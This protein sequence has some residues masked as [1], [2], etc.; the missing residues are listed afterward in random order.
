MRK[1]VHLKNVKVIAR[2]VVEHLNCK[3]NVESGVAVVIVDKE[4][5]DDEPPIAVNG[6]RVSVDELPQTLE[7]TTLEVLSECTRILYAT[8]KHLCVVFTDGEYGHIVC[9]ELNVVA[10]L[11][12]LTQTQRKT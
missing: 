8:D 12:S 6:V 2:G 9:E 3:T 7:N 10:K 11:L 1:F 4:C 5:I